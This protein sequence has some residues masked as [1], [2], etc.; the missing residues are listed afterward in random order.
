MKELS[1]SDYRA[2]TQVNLIRHI[3]LVYKGAK[4]DC[5]QCEN[6]TT[7]GIILHVKCSQYMKELGM[8]VCCRTMELL[9]RTLLIGR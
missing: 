1:R 5:N 4:Y 9:V 2:A 7:Q 8:S 6:I 3:Q